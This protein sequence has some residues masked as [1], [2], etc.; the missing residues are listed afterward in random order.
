MFLVF[1]LGRSLDNYHKVEE[2]ILGRV[3]V[4]VLEGLIYLWSMKIMHRGEN[5]HL[6]NGRVEVPVMNVKA[7]STILSTPTAITL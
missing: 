6:Q 4:S 2:Y 3:A 7:A 5:V 1:Y